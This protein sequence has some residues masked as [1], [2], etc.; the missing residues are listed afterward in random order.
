MAH[1]RFRRLENH[2]GLIG[3]ISSAAMHSVISPTVLRNQNDPLLP[4]RNLFLRANSGR[5]F[6]C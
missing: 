2:L 1:E 6:G 5:E 3:G 4:N